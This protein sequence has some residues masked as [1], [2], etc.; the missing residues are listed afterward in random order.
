MLGGNTVLL[1]SFYR[2]GTESLSG[3]AEGHVEKLVTEQGLSL[4]LLCH[5]KTEPS[6]S[7][8]PSFHKFLFVCLQLYTIKNQSAAAASLNTETFSFAQNQTILHK[9]RRRVQGSSDSVLS[10]AAS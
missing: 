9:L 4:D 2:C 10:V 1:L 7:R 6:P 3:F 8:R 5:S